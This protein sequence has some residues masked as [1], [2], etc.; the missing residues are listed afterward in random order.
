[1]KWKC[2]VVLGERFGFALDEPVELSVDLDRLET[3]RLKCFP[4]SITKEFQR[5]K[6]GVRLRRHCV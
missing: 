4:T 6:N 5:C 2:V 1:M 3:M